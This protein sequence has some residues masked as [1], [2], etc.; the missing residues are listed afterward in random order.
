MSEEAR[1]ENLMALCE[2]VIDLLHHHQDECSERSGCEK[3]GEVLIALR[4]VEK[5]MGM[6][7]PLQKG[8]GR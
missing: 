7:A 5:D 6:P 8:Q 1:R 2:R 4:R 3:V